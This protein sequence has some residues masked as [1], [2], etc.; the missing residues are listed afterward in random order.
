MLY[1]ILRTCIA[2][3]LNLTLCFLYCVSSLNVL[4][5]ILT[6]SVFLWYGSS[7]TSSNSVPQSHL[8]SLSSGPGSLVTQELLG[9]PADGAVVGLIGDAQQ[10]KAQ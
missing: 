8:P 6:Q 5:S 3:L 7:R 1:Y 2:H 9:A 4:P 10:G